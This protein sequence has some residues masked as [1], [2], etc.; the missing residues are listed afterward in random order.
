MRSERA[1]D[2][3]FLA[4][5][6]SVPAQVVMRRSIETASGALALQCFRILSE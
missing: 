5:A 3:T 2:R 6:P 4:L 1:F